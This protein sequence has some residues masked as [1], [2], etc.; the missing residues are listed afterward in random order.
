L[1][2]KIARVIDTHNGSEVA[3]DAEERHGTQSVTLLASRSPASTWLENGDANRR[4]SG[5]IDAPAPKSFVVPG[6]M[7]VRNQEM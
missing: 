7:I 3:K 6:H 2:L 1:A 5:K 4:T